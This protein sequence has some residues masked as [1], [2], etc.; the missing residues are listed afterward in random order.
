[1][2]F[3]VSCVT[4]AI[5]YLV[6]YREFYRNVLKRN[7]GSIRKRRMLVLLPLKRETARCTLFDKNTHRVQ[8]QLKFDFFNV[9]KH[10]SSDGS[11]TRLSQQIWLRY[12]H[13]SNHCKPSYRVSHRRTDSIRRM[14]YLPQISHRRTDRLA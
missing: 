3:N 14:G 6:L 2:S 10:S 4:S 1:M 13:P 5:L 9:A 7:R 8:S 11:A 12:G